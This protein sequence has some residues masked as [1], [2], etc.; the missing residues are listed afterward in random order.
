VSEIAFVD[1]GFAHHAPGRAEQRDAGDRGRVEELAVGHRHGDLLNLLGGQLV[2]AG[3]QDGADDR[4]GRRPRD[5]LDRVPGFHQRDDGAGQ[6]DALDAAAGQN[7]VRF[8]FA[9]HQRD[10]SRYG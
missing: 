1:A 5:A 2:G 3:C 9:G 7:E 10:C 8:Q 6:A 4:A